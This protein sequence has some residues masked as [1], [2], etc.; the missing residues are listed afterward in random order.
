[1]ALNYRTQT[2][3]QYGVVGS[4]D[5]YGITVFG[6]VGFECKTGNARQS[7]QQK[8]FEEMVKKMNQHYVVI[9]SAEAAVAFIKI[10]G[11]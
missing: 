2:P 9:H 8:R 4:P 7:E 5:I 1:M 11:K 6:Y 3:F 10:L